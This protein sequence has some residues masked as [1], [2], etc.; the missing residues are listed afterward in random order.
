LHLHEI[1]ISCTKKQRRANFL[2]LWYLFS[3]SLSSY[4]K[5]A[6]KMQVQ[7]IQS[8]QSWKFPVLGVVFLHF[9]FWDHISAIAPPFLTKNKLKGLPCADNL[10]GNFPSLFDKALL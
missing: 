2:A 5:Q 7:G 6:S 4:F 10:V 9:R 8:W 1:A 3:S